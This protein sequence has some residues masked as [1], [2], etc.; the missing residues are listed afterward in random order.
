M[1][2][3]WQNFIKL[4]LRNKSFAGPNLSSAVTHLISGADVISRLEVEDRAKRR[5]EGLIVESTTR[6]DRD[7]EFE[8]LVGSVAREALWEAR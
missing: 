6:E 3:L 2:P 7:H 1:D 5:R 8:I 4:T